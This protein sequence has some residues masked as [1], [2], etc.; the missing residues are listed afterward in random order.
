MLRYLHE[1]TM[2]QLGAWDGG[3]GMERLRMAWLGFAGT[4][5]EPLTV[6]A[7]A[8]TIA[9]TFA[10]LDASGALVL[11]EASGKERTVTFGDVSLAPAQPGEP[12]RGQ[13]P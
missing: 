6:N 5:G 11:R 10:G 1:A 9:G 4:L 2:R 12:P 8:Q 3:A 7:G 13:Q